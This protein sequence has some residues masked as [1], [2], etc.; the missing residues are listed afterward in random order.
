MQQPVTQP[1]T[2]RPPATHPLVAVGIAL[3]AAG[4]TAWAW[5][6]DWRWSIT[7]LAALLI[8]AVTAGVRRGRPM[9]RTG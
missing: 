5:L 2:S 9:D 6:G 7:G 1:P 8:C 4:L 3:L